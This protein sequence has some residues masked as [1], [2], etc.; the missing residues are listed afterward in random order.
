MNI[1]LLDNSITLIQECTD[2]LYQENLGPAYKILSA[3]FPK[4][5]EL[6]VEMNEDDQNV[7][8]EKLQ[9]VLEVMEQQDG[10]M[11]ADALQYELLECLKKLK[12][13]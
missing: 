3:L 9:L 13:K 6:I 5:E 2:M 11:L 4:L 10:T 7:L 8:K 12:E 1:V